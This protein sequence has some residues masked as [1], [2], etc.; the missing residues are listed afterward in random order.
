MMTKR[1]YENS[2]KRQQV[3]K[4]VL[5]QYKEKG[6]RILV[7]GEEASE[8][9]WERIFEMGEDGGCYM[10]DYLNDS[11]EQ[12]DEIRFN[13]VYLQDPSSSKKHKRNH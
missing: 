3:F 9:Q 8:S 5:K 6:G 4:D 13:K 11:S 10:G 12:R 2:K 7:D 1:E